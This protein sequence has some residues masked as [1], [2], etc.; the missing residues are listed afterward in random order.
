MLREPIIRVV[1][2]LRSI[3]AER[4]LDE[5]LRFHVEQQT[6]ANIA[7]GMAPE[8]ARRQALVALGGIDKTRE[9]YR[10]ALGFCLLSDFAQDVRYALRQMRRSPAFTIVAV[11]T[12][13]LGIGANTAIF[14]FVNT[15]FLKAL[16]AQ[17]P[18]LLVNVFHFEGRR[19]SYSSLS[20]PDY[21]D[22]RQTG[23]LEDLAAFS[24][25]T[26]H[27]SAGDRNERIE[28][29]IV[30]RNYFGLLGVQPALGRAF[31]PEEQP[32]VVLGH[33]F[34]QRRF[35]GSPTVLGSTITL[36][37]HPFTVIGIAPKGFAGTQ[38]GEPPALWV[39]LEMHA[40]LMP[41]PFKDWDM[42][43]ARMSNRGTH[44][45]D[46]IGRLRPGVSVEQANA[47]LKLRARQIAAANPPT[48]DREWSA[49]V[50]P[51]NRSKVWPDAAVTMRRFLG[52]LF[53]V[54]GLV[55]LIACVN[56]AG[57]LL[58]RSAAR[59]KETAVRL[60][61]GATRF[62]LFRQSIT[63]ALLLAWL[64]GAA[65]IVL[66]V[67]LSAL[68]TGLKLGAWLDLPRPAFD[69]RLFLFAAAV[70]LLA[71]VLAGVTPAIHAWRRDVLPALKQAPSAPGR[72]GTFAVRWSLVVVQV[73]LSLVLLAATGLLVR[74]LQNERMIQP[75]FETR[76]LLLASFDLHLQGY[77]EKRSA[78]FDRQLVERIGNLPGVQSASL[79]V[80]VPLSGRRW[81]TNIVLEDDP[82]GSAPARE[83]NL[84]LNL[85]GPR[86]FETA[87]IPVVA[88]RGFTS[89]DREGSLPVAIVNESMERRFWPGQNPLGK[90]FREKGGSHWIEVVG[91]VRDT[92]YRELREDFKPC[93]YRP[94][95]QKPTGAVA[96]L[97]ARTPGNPGP[98][99]EAI[100]A[101]VRALD[102]SLPLFDVKTMEDHYQEAFAQSRAIAAFVG[103][104]STVA[105][106]LAAVGLYGIVSYAVTQARH[107]IGIRMALG[108]RWHHVLRLFVG[109][110]I[111]LIVAGL[112]VGLAGALAAGRLVGSF[113]YGVEP[114]DAS[115][116][117]AAVVLLMAVALLASYFP[118]RR[119]AKVDPVVVLRCE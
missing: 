67:W 96:T 39:P 35:G 49:V 37:G 65:G 69:L 46:A 108:A 54:S 116:I 42:A 30:T 16:P 57:M 25:L 1:A 89:V 86:Y 62:H 50:L 32:E 2:L 38:L 56:V 18:D 59:A 106:I 41:S 70:S 34:W 77:D 99:S 48:G 60:A 95:F 58:A 98:L 93:F 115:T 88:G 22:F 4:E 29:E 103:L 63:E 73:A 51:A 91:V 92:K 83:Y 101:E 5:E 107:E 47:A 20:Y 55:L 26:L 109:R 19:G 119:A 111:K 17:D 100:R 15:M 52:L 24:G 84:N 72:T 79:A 90:R 7:A 118:A 53:A 40:Q 12:L 66:G 68:L 3:R 33:D 76:H 14:S 27:L 117:A 74:S 71:A 36:N 45:L 81:A 110:A 105:L 75:G 87:G 102:R 10:D 23:V 80:V 8:E 13:A 6:E 11:L 9:E 104:F 43:K 94:I 85:V 82:S 112:A 97:Y 64:G 114:A 78:I 113:L 28:G 21:L 61:L 31:S 44:W